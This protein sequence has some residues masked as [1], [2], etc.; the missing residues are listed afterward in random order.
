MKEKKSYTNNCRKLDRRVRCA[1]AERSQR[2]VDM[3]A[4]SVGLTYKFSAHLLSTIPLLALT[5]KTVGS[6]IGP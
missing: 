1:C 5:W 3:D 2:Y 4:I 6:L